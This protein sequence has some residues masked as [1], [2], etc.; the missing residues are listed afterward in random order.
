MLSRTTGSLL[1]LSIWEIIFQTLSIWT[2]SA[3][4]GHRGSQLKSKYRYCISITAKNS[5]LYVI[6]QMIEKIII[7]TDIFTVNKT[8]RVQVPVRDRPSQAAAHDDSSLTKSGAPI[9]SIRKELLRNGT[10][11]YRFQL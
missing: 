8:N 2:S 10:A 1:G 4:C 6:G 5:D 3:G 11:C 9:A 7:E